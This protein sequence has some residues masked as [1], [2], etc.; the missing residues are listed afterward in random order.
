MSIL[1]KILLIPYIFLILKNQ[2]LISKYLGDKVLLLKD[3]NIIILFI[4]TIISFFFITI[5]CLIPFSLPTV[6]KT[7]NIVDKGYDKAAMPIPG[8][9]ELI[10][11]LSTFCLFI[12]YSINLYKI[13]WQA[14]KVDNYVFRI[15]LMYAVYALNGALVF[16][17]FI[18]GFIGLIASKILNLFVNNKKSG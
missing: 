3:A 1:I 7:I 15:L 18:F 5:L 2:K 16:T 4:I 6:I 10:A 17:I 11:S 12:N 13:S 9:I 14:A 8:R